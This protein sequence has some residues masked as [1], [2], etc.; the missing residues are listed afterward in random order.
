M[1]SKRRYKICV[2]LVILGD[3]YYNG[4]VIILP[5]ILDAILRITKEK[6]L[7]IPLS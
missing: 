6:I 7:L 1:H 5:E 2:C 3:R 4:F